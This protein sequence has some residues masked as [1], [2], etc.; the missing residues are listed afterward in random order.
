MKSKFLIW[1]FW[2][3]SLPAF[4]QS[5]TYRNLVFEGGG[6]K[7]IAYGGALA[8]ME[9]LGVL[10]SI[11]RVAGTSAGAIQAA[12]FA[13]GYNA[14]EITEII[15]STPIESFNDDGFIVRGTKRLLKKFG[16]FKGEAFHQKMI[17]LIAQRTGNP[18]LT[19]ADLHQLARSHPFRDLYV[20]GTNLTE[21]RSEIFSHEKYPQMRIA[22]AVRISM[23]IPLFYEAIWVDKQGKIWEEGC[24]DCQLYVDGGLLVNYPIHIFDQ[25]EFLPAKPAEEDAL[26]NTQT[27]GLRLERCEQIQYDLNQNQTSAP[28]KIQDFGSFMG[29]L[30]DLLMRNVA[31]PHPRDPQR[32]IYINDMGFGFMPR[33]VPIEEKELLINSGRQAVTEF[34]ALQSSLTNSEEE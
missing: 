28:K 33:K 13:L 23:S 21:Q 5:P 1:L 20:T 2:G 10:S 31:S 4:T 16:W 17:E 8:E 34:F 25:P 29:S 14:E 6:I 30:S 19:F 3:L 11:T 7:G 15:H 27:I 24:T 22:D 32:T 9:N 26:F 12:L 18:N